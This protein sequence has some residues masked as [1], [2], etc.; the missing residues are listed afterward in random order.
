M[1]E[2]ISHRKSDKVMYLTNRWSHSQYGFLLRKYK[3]ANSDNEDYD[4][5]I[6][7]TKT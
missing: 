5:L 7:S 4:N 6:V 1:I 3:M 2:E